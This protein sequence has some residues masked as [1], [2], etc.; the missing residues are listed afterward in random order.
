LQATLQIPKRHSLW[1]PRT[2]HVTPPARPPC[3]RRMHL[4]K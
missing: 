4:I 3:Y 1:P 2:G